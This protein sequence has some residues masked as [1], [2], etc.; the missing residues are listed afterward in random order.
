MLHRYA[1]TAQT[2]FAVVAMATLLAGC[3]PGMFGGTARMEMHQQE[4][5]GF[6]AAGEWTAAA[7]AWQMAAESARGADRDAAL[8][9]AAEAWLRAGDLDALRAALA[10]MS[11]QPGPSLAVRAALV[12]ARALLKENRPA[13]ARAQ[14]AGLPAGAG[15]SLAAS[16]LAVRADAAFATGEPA[17]GLA[18]LMRRDALLEDAAARAANQRRAWNRLQEAIAAGLPLQTPAGADEGVAAWLALGRAAREAGGNLFRMRASLV[19]WR[20]AYPEHPAAAL[21]DRLLAEY[22]AMTR[23]PERIALLLPT[24]GR[25]AAAAQAV[26]DGFIAGYLAQ[27]GDDPRPVISVYDTAAP[28]VTAAY[29]QAVQEG[30]DFIVGPLLK[31]ELAEIATADLPAVPTLALNWTDDGIAAPAYMFQYA[32][33]P[34]QE[35]AAA[36]RRAALDGHARALVLAHDTGQGR[37]M[38][39]SFMQAFGE[40]GGEVLGWRAYNPRASDFSAEITSL[41]LLDESRQ[42]HRRI[43]QLTGLDL[44]YEPRR[45]HDADLLFLAARA[46]EARLI[47]P[48]LRF[49]YASGLPVYATS[50]VYDATRDEHGDLDGILFADMPW[51]VGAEGMDFMQRFRAFGAGAVQRNGRLYAFGADA[52]Q[53]VPLLH[54]RSE[55]LSSGVEGLT[56]VLSLAADGRVQREPAWGRFRGGRVWHAPPPEPEPTPTPTTVPEAEEAQVRVLAPGS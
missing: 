15:D 12:E 30:A 18:A 29:T 49:H 9:S 11:A 5:R 32:L 34:E 36:A 16:I 31:D 53:L 33:A 22:R 20:E 47:R 24:S 26:Q 55:S 35:A 37:R 48:Q 42:R 46:S 40:T 21:V 10:G 14:L 17:A 8:V 6:E 25:Q 43:E 51:R 23:Y 1:R 50:S 19:E 28:G 7:E 2:L 52:Y 41:L 39:E 44:G 3:A 27:E 45:R 56:G 38:A 13:E 4:A 54:N